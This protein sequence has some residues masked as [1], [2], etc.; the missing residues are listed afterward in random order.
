MRSKCRYYD[1]DDIL[2][3]AE[4]LP[5]SFNVQA[6][7]L[8]FLDDTTDDPDL[9]QGTK[10]KLPVWVAEIFFKKAI[11]SITLPSFFKPRFR[12]N[13]LADP[14]VI[15]LNGRCSYYYE[16]GMKLAVEFGQLSIADFL[17]KTFTHRFQDILDMSQN[18]VAPKVDKFYPRLTEME[19]QIFDRKISSCKKYLQWK[20][21]GMPRLKTSQVIAV[22]KRRKISA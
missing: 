21:E 13:I 7:N 20:K 10:L 11:I 1:L 15:H 3:E 12:E 5:C 6:A 18:T 19:R 17:E 8:G 2:T 4:L 16:L 14:S 9:E 22:F